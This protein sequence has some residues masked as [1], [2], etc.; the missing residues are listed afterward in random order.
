MGT[1][2]VELLPEPEYQTPPYEKVE[3]TERKSLRERGSKMNEEQF[4]E[5]E[6][7]YQSAEVCGEEGE[8]RVM[9]EKS[10]KRKNRATRLKPEFIPLHECR[11]NAKN[12]LE[13]EDTLK[14]ARSSFYDLSLIHICRCRRY[15]VCRS[16]WSPYH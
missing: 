9:Q 12:A 3:G 5:Y 6:R 7:V 11:D 1:E 16:R 10:A 4:D 15:A 8:W 14:R 2:G 13:G